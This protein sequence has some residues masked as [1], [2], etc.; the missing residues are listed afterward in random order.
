MLKGKRSWEGEIIPFLKGLLLVREEPPP[1]ER[2]EGAWDTK[3]QWGNCQSLPVQGGKIW[4]RE[5]GLG[6]VS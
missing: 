5:R 2:G 6:Q 1:V 4:V 3:L